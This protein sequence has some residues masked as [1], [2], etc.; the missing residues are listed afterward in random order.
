[1]L[2]ELA[3]YRDAN[4]LYRT[5]LSPQDKYECINPG[6]DPNPAD[7]T[8]QMNVY[9]MLRKL[10]PPAAQELCTALQRAFGDDD[11]WVYY[12][13]APLLPYLRSAELTQLGCALPLPAERLAAAA[14]G[15][16]SWSEAGSLL[17]AALAAPQD[18]D[19]Q[20]ALRDLLVRIGSDD[21]A[22]LRRSPP[23]LY[24]N[25][26][27]ASV[28]RFYWSEDFSY[29]LWLRLYAAAKGIN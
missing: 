7:V 6:R 4:G 27:T 3:R 14:P 26:L 12:A 5:W 9:L 19:V 16:E 17:L 22:Q 2:A 25:D 28:S 10:D 15:Q 21:F 20:Q 11:N 13:K 29:A 18:L 8:I 24:H 23:L 1:M